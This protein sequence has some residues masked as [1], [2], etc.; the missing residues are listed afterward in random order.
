MNEVEVIPDVCVRLG[1]AR[2]YIAPLLDVGRLRVVAGAGIENP[3]DSAWLRDFHT[4]ALHEE[5]IRPFVHWI[6]LICCGEHVNNLAL[7]LGEH[8]GESHHG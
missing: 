1:T 6:G 4:D 3:V 2:H 7:L 5:N 8:E